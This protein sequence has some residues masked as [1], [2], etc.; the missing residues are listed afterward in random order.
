M[1]LKPLILGIL[2]IAGG[3]E[4]EEGEVAGVPSL[5]FALSCCPFFFFYFFFFQ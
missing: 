4:K 3:S 1:N 5:G 2:I